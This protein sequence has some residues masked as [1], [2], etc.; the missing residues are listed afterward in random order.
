M[1]S[2][3]GVK[4][5]ESRAL[6]V[7]FELP[8][9]APN[10]DQLHFSV[11]SSGSSIR[12]TGVVDAAP[13]KGQWGT[14]YQMS[15]PLDPGSYTIDLAGEKNGRYA[16]TGKLSVE[17][18]AIPRAGTWMSPVWVATEVEPDSKASIGDP[19]NIGGWHLM[20]ISDP[21]LTRKDEISY[22]GFIV[23]PSFNRGVPWK[24]R[25]ISR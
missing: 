19:F 20:P 2:E 11:S 10:L 23:R 24:S 18:S 14:A 9:S 15:I 8:S 21:K 12:S 17:V 7:H 16:V 4:N 1:V 6:W 13:A 22:F 5:S 25:H 3:L